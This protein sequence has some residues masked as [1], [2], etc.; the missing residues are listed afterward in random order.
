V[1]FAVDGFVQVVCGTLNATHYPQVGVCMYGFGLSCSSKEPSHLSVSILVGL[2][3][4]R[5]ILA[6]GLTFTGEGFL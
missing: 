3:G 1:P 4:K 2:F 6:I 5:K